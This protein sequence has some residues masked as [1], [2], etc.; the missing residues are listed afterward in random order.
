MVDDG[1]E[2]TADSTDEGGLEVVDSDECSGEDEVEEF[3]GEEVADE[4]ELMKPF[5]V[6]CNSEVVIAGL[7]PTEELDELV[8]DIELVRCNDSLLT[9]GED[10]LEDFL[11]RSRHS[12][13]LL[14]SGGEDI[15]DDAVVGSDDSVDNGP[16]VI[17]PPFPI[18]VEFKEGSIA[19]SVV[20]LDEDEEEVFI[21]PLLDVGFSKESQTMREEEVV[22]K[23][24]EEEDDNFVGW[25]LLLLLYSS[26]PSEVGTDEE[27]GECCCCCC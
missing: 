17:I 18:I 1:G 4:D 11:L 16:L 15:E 19:L 10:S 26:S 7:T 21:E 23:D 3:D 14:A 2:E 8:E 9:E 22:D 20:E 6:C 13:L 12:L 25:L 27:L 5:N 24:D